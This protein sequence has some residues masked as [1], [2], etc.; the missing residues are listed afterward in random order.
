MREA[1][2]ETLAIAA[3]TVVVLRG[4]RICSWLAAS[5]SAGQDCL[6]CVMVQGW[7]V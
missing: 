5:L 3:G 6:T 1:V 2:V 4:I 7:L